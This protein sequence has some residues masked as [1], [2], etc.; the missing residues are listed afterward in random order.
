[1]QKKKI[2]VLMGSSRDYEF[3]SR[4]K[5]FLSEEK[6]PVECE[7]NV[8]SAHKTPEKLIEDL[9]RCEESGDKIVYITVAGL[10]DA[11][12]GVVAGVTNHPVI[13][14]PPD[15]EKY[16]WAK[17][18]SS[19]FTPRGVA[20]AFV[21]RPENAALVAVSILAISDETL[22]EALAKYKRKLVKNVYEASEQIKAKVE[23]S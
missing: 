11:L 18:F 6:F 19:S 12:S 16:G 9:R 15:V 5:N 2:I 20:V 13:A 22:R 1:M 14:C 23:E 21:S 7:Y 4:V 8:A 10:S 3:A 17:V